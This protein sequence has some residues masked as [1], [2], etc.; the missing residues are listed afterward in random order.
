MKAFI[1]AG[2][3]ATRLWPLTEKR[4]KPLLPLGG[5]PLLSYVVDAIP[6]EIPVT[7]STNAAFAKDF[8]DWKKRENRSDI[9][10]AIEDAG[11]EREKVGA[12]GAVALWIEK[13][14]IEDD[15]LL[16]AGDNYVGTDMK[17]FLK[18][19][20]DAPLVA[21]HDIGSLDLARQFGTIV[22]KE[23]DAKVS[24]VESFEEKPR[25][26]KSTVVSTGWWVL[27]KSALSVL[28]EH[29]KAH[30]DNV[31]GVFEEFL[32]REIAVDCFVFKE[33]WK[34]IGSFDAYIG[35]HREVIGEKHIVDSSS[36]VHP[37]S[38]LIGAIDIGP[39]VSI[40]ASTLTDCIVFGKT[41]IKDCVVERCIIDEGCTLEGIDL[42][43]KMLRT[44]TVLKRS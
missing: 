33:I 32:K 29:A 39:E 3:F 16:L 37:S 26:P 11:H 10:I 31:G 22:L 2:G 34:D 19:F 17:E 23:P 43:D 24:R 9:V 1:L 18:L 14:K 13:E 6:S 4:A 42:T 20:K 30:P 15:V 36:R 38:K 5:R 7:V 28:T 12:L 27:P 25:H 40:E 41:S 8:D 21:G 44:G 35:L